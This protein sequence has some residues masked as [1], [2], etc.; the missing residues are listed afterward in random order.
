MSESLKAQRER[1]ARYVAE[2]GGPG[3]LGMCAALRELQRSAIEVGRAHARGGTKSID[4]L[5]DSEGGE[6]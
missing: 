2:H 4:E 1:V 5:L 6:I 3:S